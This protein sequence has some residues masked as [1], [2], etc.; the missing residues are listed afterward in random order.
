M[1]I[2]WT[3]NWLLVISFH[4]FEN[5]VSLHHEEKVVHEI[6]QD[7][8]TGLNWTSC[9]SQLSK[10]SSMFVPNHS[11]AAGWDAGQTSLQMGNGL[12]KWTWNCVI[13]EFKKKRISLLQY[14]C[15]YPHNLSYFSQYFLLN[16][17]LCLSH[18][19]LL[20]FLYH[21]NPFSLLDCSLQIV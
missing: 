8:P 5:L 14:L 12:R 20:F 2:A 10:H 21:T 9:L 1:L 16:F 13:L 11:K 18:N 6:T 7:E 19:L 15:P 3:A 4:F 17:L